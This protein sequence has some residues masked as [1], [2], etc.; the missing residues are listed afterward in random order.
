[1]RTGFFSKLMAWVLIAQMLV[2]PAGYA[3]S[4]GNVVTQM[5]QE[6]LGAQQAQ[7][8]QTEAQVRSTQ[9]RAF[10]EPRNCNNRQCTSEY[11]PGCNILRSI[12]NI[13]EASACEEG[14]L[15]PANPND[16]ARYLDALSLISDYG[17]LEDSYRNFSDESTQRG[18]DGMTCLA[19]A[20]SELERSLKNRE[21]EI[22]LLIRR[23][24]EMQ[25]RQFKPILEA[26]L[27]VIEDS[28]ALLQG[29]QFQG[30]KAALSQNSFRFSD[31]FKGAPCNSVFGESRFNS[32]GRRGGLNAIQQ[33]LQDTVS[34]PASPGNPGS[35]AAAGFNSDTARSLSA[36]IARISTS[37]SNDIRS[38]GPGALATSAQGINDTYG[39]LPRLNPILQ[40]QA[41]N[42]NSFQREL[43]QEANR[44][45]SPSRAQSLYSSLFNES[46]EVFNN[47]ITD[48]ENEFNRQCLQNHENIQRLL[49][50]AISMRIQGAQG[51]ANVNLYRAQLAE[52]INNPTLSLEEKKNRIA[53]LAGP[54]YIVELNG[55]L[56]S[57]SGEGNTTGFTGNTLS[58]AQFVDMHITNCQRRFSA[59]NGRSFSDREMLD[60]FRQTR[61]RY[62]AYRRNLPNQVAA[63]INNRLNSCADAQQANASGVATC[64]SADLSTSNSSFCVSRALSCANKM[65]AC[66]QSAQQQVAS[67][68]ARRDQAVNRY[69]ANVQRNQA[70]LIAMHSELNRILEIQ[71]SVI[72]NNSP[73]RAALV[74]PEGI[75][76][77]LDFSERAGGG[78]QGNRNYVRGLADLEIQNPETYFNKAKENLTKVKEALERQR[79]EIMRGSDDSALQDLAAAGGVKGHIDRIRNS[80][81]EGLERASEQ[82]EKCKRSVRRYLN[83][84]RQMLAEQARQAAE[85]NERLE[86]LCTNYQALNASPGCENEDTFESIIEAAGRARQRSSAEAVAVGDYARYCRSLNS[87]ADI[88][89][90]TSDRDRASRANSH[91]EEQTSPSTD[92]RVLAVT[93]IPD[94]CV[95]LQPVSP[96]RANSDTNATA[97]QPS[98]E[99]R[100]NSARAYNNLLALF[101]IESGDPDCPAYRAGQQISPS[102]LTKIRRKWSEDSNNPLV[103]F[104]E[105]NA[106]SNLAALRQE[107]GLRVYDNELRGNRR[108]A[109]SGD[110]DRW[111]RSRQMGENRPSACSAQ[112]NSGPGTTERVVQEFNNGFRSATGQ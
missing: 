35:F 109:N 31:S 15:D 14:Q 24:K 57:D 100:V 39:L 18:T 58:P 5:L 67:V 111:N 104:C 20:A 45:S 47:A 85:A 103:S 112:D 105:G 9:R 51:R 30:R 33:T 108:L 64:S 101:E 55:S 43:T 80:M 102:C 91:C 106:N 3:Q 27:T 88:P 11:F 66:Y 70:Q 77:T 44:Y 83:D 23:M 56:V 34:T 42:D 60:K 37:I 25:D 93:S 12:P 26:D 62:S 97:P 96:S 28:M 22:D 49:S 54:N 7:L 8:A 79:R 48:Y 110:P 95:N 61:A 17:Y 40:E 1:M 94:L 53:N 6:L 89:A 16:Q 52:I 65:N 107:A 74:L 71:S 4:A 86:E 81:R 13:V 2:A 99:V 38:S 90:P 19:R 73:L 21:N 63:A 98:V 87:Q 78:A 10:I 41:R 36:E 92:C 59:K 82:K 46:D 76:I 84:Q 50:G 75:D 68:T 69:R 72:A 29:D 32:D